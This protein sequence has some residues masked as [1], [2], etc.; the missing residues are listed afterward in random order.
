MGKKC[1]R[2]LKVSAVSALILVILHFA[3]IWILP[4]SSL[5]EFRARPYSVTVYDRQM[6]LIQ[7]TAV[8]DGIRR[9]YTPFDQIPEEIKN[10]FIKAEDNRFY[11]HNGVDFK[12]ALRAFKQNTSELRTVSG[13]STITMQLARIISPSEKRN[14]L[15]KVK[16]VYNAWRIEARLSKDE[17]LEYYLNTLP[18]GNNVEGITSAARY[19]FNRDLTELTYQQIYALAVIPRSPSAYNPILHPENCAK[20]A[21]LICEKSEEEIASSLAD[22]SAFQWPFLMPHFV[23]HLKTIYGNDFG[24]TKTELHTT[25]D[26]EAQ[27]LAQ[28]LVFDYLNRTERARIDNAAVLVIENKTG[29]VLVWSGSRNWFDNEHSGQIDGI[30]VPNQMGSSMKPFLYAQALENGMKPSQVLPDIPMDFGSDSVYIPLNFNNRFNGP[31]ILRT[32]L[33]S[34]LNVPAVYTLSQTGVPD[35]YQLLLQLGFDSL[36]K[37]GMNADLGLALGAG[38]VTLQELTTAF[39]VF[40]R[41]GIYIPLTYEENQLPDE[42]RTYPVYSP[43]TARIICSILSDKK[44]RAA[45]FGFSQTFQTDYPAIFKTGTANQYQNIVA[46]GSTAEYTVGVWMGNHSGNTVM[47]KTGSSLPA[48][49]ARELLDHL[50]KKT[51]PDFK[52]P[53]NYTMTKICSLSGLSPSKDCPHVSEEYVRNDEINLFQENKCTWHKI[54]NG[55]LKGYMHN[56]ESAAKYGVNPCGNARAYEFSDEPLI[57]MRNTAILPGKSKLEEMIASIDDGYYFIRTGNGQADLTGEFMFGVDFGYE[58]KNGKL[59]RGLRNSTISGIAFEMLQT[60]DMLSD[61]MVWDVGMCGKKQSIPVGMGG[62]AV[63]CRLTVGGR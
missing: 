52:K 44:A 17:I 39:S 37:D 51:S 20:A 56:R 40:A 21:S 34:S 46:L 55:I 41:D 53:K 33:A 10:A 38:E 50:T 23:E 16:D 12:A 2:F 25:A 14:I 9:Q 58:I 61:E 5:K 47:G 3:V 18:F 28:Y 31:V 4:F 59:G 7:V 62:P 30:K 32:A 11:S 13:A 29:A 8:E 22:L 19:Y 48:T 27:D 15:A 45:G 26:L 54:E 60:V 57:R 35:Y 43:D 36:K 1:K 63:K 24:T 6:N 42:S 49:I